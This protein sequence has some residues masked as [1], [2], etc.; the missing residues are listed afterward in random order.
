MLPPLAHWQKHFENNEF[1]NN[2]INWEVE[3][4]FTEEE[5]KHIKKSLPAFQLGESSEG[6]HLIQAAKDYA[7]EQNDPYLVAI[8]RLFIKEEQGHAL[9]LKR[10][11]DK[12]KIPTLKKLWADDVF[13][14][15][16]KNVGFELSVT[17][18]ITAELL[19]LIY[20]SALFNATSNKLLKSICEKLVKD[21][22]VHIKYE[23]ELLNHIRN[24][25]PFLIKQL[26]RFA[27]Q[28]FYFGTMLVVYFSHHRILNAGDYSFGRFWTACWQEF[29]YCFGQGNVLKKLPRRVSNSAIVS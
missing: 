10:F 7:N 3:D 20:Y 18:L 25:K 16:R 5:Y 23:S 2:S 28:F 11:M 26:T 22:V 8:T 12:H 21:E 9:L 1:S 13:R 6:K 14:K 17:I 15:L 24:E 27:H 29:S 19:S 4:I